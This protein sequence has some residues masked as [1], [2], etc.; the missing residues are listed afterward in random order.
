M[1]VPLGIIFKNENQL[2]QM[3][4]IM[5]NLH[6]YVPKEVITTSES[7]PGAEAENDE[8][9]VDVMHKILLGGDQLTVAR[10]RGAQRIRANSQHGAGRLEGWNMIMSFQRLIIVVELLVQVKISL[11]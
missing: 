8:A 4:T 7:V 6:H 11:K 10:A 3:V 5:E 1:Q 2:D 9:Q